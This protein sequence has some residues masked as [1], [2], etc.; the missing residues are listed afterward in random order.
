MIYCIWYPSG[1]FGHFVNAII[2]LHGE[3]FQ[4]PKTQNLSFSKSGDSHSL[5]LAA[6]KY[7]KDPEN[8]DFE[9]N[10]DK[11]YSVL[12]DNGINNEGQKFLSVFPNSQVIK[13]CYSDYSWPVIS[14]TLINKAMKSSILENFNT[15]EW[16]SNESWTLREKYFLYLRD[17]NLR[18]TWK[19]SANVNN[20]LIEDLLDYNKLKFKIENSGI[21]LR[22]FKDIWDQWHAS[23][24]RYFDHI[25]IAQQVIDS[26]KH[27]QLLNLEHVTDIWTQAVIYYYIWLEFKIE[28]PHNDYA[29]F[30]ETTDQIRKWLKL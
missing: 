3:N 4:K 11:N 30:F 24:I 27:N 15:V 25:I 12:V 16:N 2:S 29:D 7:L 21:V 6:P 9:F 13:L 20:I 23:N 28:V 8:Y 18:H 5:E 26:V 22:E 17:H 10:I 14:L 1:G 19:P